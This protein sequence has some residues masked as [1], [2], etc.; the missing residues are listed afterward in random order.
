M[1]LAGIPLG[2]NVQIRFIG[3]GDLYDDVAITVPDA[4]DLYSFTLAQGQAATLAACVVKGGA[5]KLEL[6]DAA[7][8]LLAVGRTGSTNLDQVVSGFVAPA[9]GTY[10]LRITGDSG[11]EY[12]ATVVRGAAMDTER[13]NTVAQAQDLGPT[14]AVLG[15]V[16][17]NNERLF[18]VSGNTGS[19]VILSELVPQT[20]GVRTKITTP[21]TV[22]STFGIA[23]VAVTDWSVLVAATS[24]YPIYE[25]AL[26][27]WQIAR[28]IPN[29]GYHFS[30]L[31]VLGTEIFGVARNPAGGGNLQQIIVLDYDTG[32]V[33]RAIPL[34]LVPD[35]LFTSGTTLYC[36]YG[37]TLYT[38]NPQTGALVSLGS[39]GS[40]KYVMAVRGDEIL[41][42]D[43]SS[44]YLQVYD[45]K[46]LAFKRS[47]S[48][49]QADYPRAYS[50]GIGVVDDYYRL[51]A[52]AGDP[53]TLS[54]ATPSTGPRTYAN[55]LDPA[56]D[57]YD[58]SGAL[59]A[60]NA[61]GAPD[62]RNAQIAW[63]ATTSGVYT[64]RVSAKAG[65]A[66]EYVL[67]ASGAR[68]GAGF[69][70][71]VTSPADG[72][73]LVETPSS[74]T[75]DFSAGVLLTTLHASDLTLDGVAATG[76]TVVDGDT[77]TFALPA[78]AEGPHDVRI[79][80]GAVS[81]VAGRPLAAVATRFYLRQFAYATPLAA[82]RP[83]GTLVYE[84]TPADGFI[85]NSGDACFHTLSLD[86]GQM[87]GVLVTP[88][89][90]LLAVVDVYDPFGARVGGTTAAAAGQAVT[91]LVPVAST[92]QYRVVVHGASGTSGAYKV[93]LVV[94]AAVEAEG[95]GGP[96]DNSLA[97]A[98]N[99][100]GSFSALAPGILRGGVVGQADSSADGLIASENFESGALGA[101]WTTY[102][103]SSYS[104]V[105]FSGTYG[106]GGGALA[107]LMDSS[108]SG[109]SALNEAVWTVNLSG[110]TRAFLTFDSAAWGL[111]YLDA[112]SGN[113]TGH[114]NA[115]GVSISADGVTWHPVWTPRTTVSGVWTTTS[116]D[117][118]KEAAAAGMTL[119]AGFRIKFQQYDHDS[120]ATAGRGWDDLSVGDGADWYAVTVSGGDHV[121]VAVGAAS[122]GPFAVDLYNAAG[123][124]VAAGT[125]GA[126]TAEDAARTF[127]S[128]NLSSPQRAVFG[129]DGNL[130]V[131]NSS[132]HNV[133][134]FNG[135]TGAYLGVF[136]PV[137]NAPYAPRGLAFGP[138]GNLY[139][140]DSNSAVLR[141]NGT[142]GAYLGHFTDSY[143]TLSS[144]SGLAFG[145]DGNLYV[146]CNDNSRVLRFNGSTG[147]YMGVFV[148]STAGNLQLP[149][150]LA[151]GPDGNL[152]VSNYTGNNIQR[153]N[154]QTG[155]FMGVFTASVP[156]SVLS[157]P[158]D[159]AFG[160]D[161]N[162]YV[163]CGKSAN[164][165]CFDGRTGAFVGEVV[166]P[167]G[168]SVHTIQGI[169]FGPDKAL[170]TVSS[171]TNTILRSDFSRLSGAA[172]SIAD[173]GALAAGTY[174]ARVSGAGAYTLTVLRN[175]QFDLEPNNSA[176]ERETIALALPVV[177][178]LGETPFSRDDWFSL[179]ITAGATVTFTTSTPAN[180]P[181][182]SAPALNPALAIY[183][184]TG[185]L[186][187][188]ALGGAAD[189]RNVVLSYQAPTSGVY[190][191]R[192]YAESGA[193]P[194]VLTASLGGIGGRAP[195]LKVRPTSKL[196][197]KPLALAA[198]DPSAAPG[199]PGFGDGPATAAPA[200]APAQDSGPGEIGMDEKI[201]AMPA[202]RAVAWPG[203]LG[204]GAV[205]ELQ[206]LS[207][208]EDEAAP[209]DRAD[210]LAA[211]PPKPTTLFAGV[212]AAAAAPE[213]VLPIPAIE[214]L[215]DVSAAP[216]PEADECLVDVLDLAALHLP[217]GA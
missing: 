189:G 109:Y 108:Y 17:V 37:S 207:S 176:T 38:V 93:L 20:G 50:G 210:V 141:Y 47:F 13:N 8:N 213:R 103:S 214:I 170:Y 35:R 44:A 39:V 209:A 161:G 124:R 157:G 92:G 72:S 18:C 116:I 19:P 22:S 132:G 12:S 63:T 184:P 65:T 192:L 21:I 7:G 2:P 14:G 205:P 97:S 167:T 73:Q 196:P 145:P 166:N 5:L 126:V 40:S 34:S 89:A 26:D 31:A 90:G 82:Q 24:D 140:V 123:L 113:Y 135:A 133:L 86:A 52:N 33:K 160:P 70:A 129:P 105:S 151:F 112:F 79:A 162:L 114:V 75:L 66:G 99:L 130:Y 180:G 215:P 101:A 146:S 81:D 179:S 102:G 186:V 121:S 204:A 156:T 36:G 127:I 120:A 182:A 177:G 137:A 78:L 122:G 178:S 134:K 68:A 128:A 208:E 77:V 171:D 139:V 10:Y 185:T 3:A 164:V 111:E 193:G 152:Y 29:P 197:P 174:Y 15:D 94:N 150:G 217:L 131:S 181:F 53:L 190:Q 195:A 96:S 16:G 202:A 119:G 142:T 148:S 48:V 158:M 110:R 1:A 104:R 138:D 106:T 199:L 46:T 43:N 163:A 41:V 100:D 91:L 203:D 172:A 58:P 71:Q 188:S 95:N 49:G 149:Y 117:L 74:V 56:L 200:A 84:G 187:A 198:T 55:R 98:Q 23:A 153:Y 136:T 54:T 61:D 32:A 173:S 191:V 27:T 88:T 107:L 6:L 216:A 64:V 143:G 159:L 115:D 85:P 83:Y 28:T 201:A 11:V 147:A 206:R 169:L 60:S 9:A 57:L 45:L 194:Y 4:A 25:Y 76:F 211:A 168:P 87:L 175:G 69:T 165:L 42:S 62:G 30:G 80:A 51:S 67:R 155:A 144:A 183:S 212:R 118:A 125:P 154:G 59:V